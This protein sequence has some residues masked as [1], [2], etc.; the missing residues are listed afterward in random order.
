MAARTTE[1][2][3]KISRS[4]KAEKTRMAHLWY[5]QILTAVSGWNLYIKA[6]SKAL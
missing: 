3:I 6:E 2:I 1:I 4:A 5:H